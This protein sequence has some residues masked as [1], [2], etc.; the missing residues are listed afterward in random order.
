MLVAFENL[1]PVF[2][3]IA[4]GVALK[5]IGLLDA[6]MWQGLERIT[7]FVLFPA[8][9]VVTL[10]A[11]DLTSAPVLPLAGALLASI[12]TM[13]A[14]LLLLR[15]MLTITGPA[16]TSLFQGATRWN[17]YVAIGIAF[18][19]YGK[20]GTALMAI[21]VA[22]MIPT[23]NSAAVI[24]LALFGERADGAVPTFKSVLTSL[25]QNP[26]IVACVA[27]IGIKL[28]GLPVYAPLMATGDQL[29]KATIALGLLVVGSGLTLPR[30]GK[31]IEP[32]ALLSTAL[33][34]GLMPVLAIGY[35]AWFGVTGPALQIA[36][37]SMAVPTAPAAYILARQLGGDAELMARIISLQTLI[38]LVTM[39]LWLGLVG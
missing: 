28:S 27:G 18:S 23:V 8:L 2:L 35:C 33:R 37:L 25:A 29:G 16:F 26:L 4:L 17:S 22:A 24:V 7:Y 5:R 13:T 38:A 36:V 31:N 12:A 9:L 21:A 34:L 30:G 11:S 15:P 32:V 14:L 19:L 39:P 1:L 3:I 6:A 20:P 10:V